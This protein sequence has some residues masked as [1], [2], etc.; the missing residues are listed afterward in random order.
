MTSHVTGADL[1]Q[2]AIWH[3][4]R[5][6][7][8]GSA[9]GVPAWSVAPTAA[10]I[11]PII[12]AAGGGSGSFAVPLAVEGYLV[13]V[14]DP[15]PDA[16]AALRR[17]ADERG[18]ADRVTAEQG[19]LGDLTGIVGTETADL[20]LC[21]SVLDVVDDPGAALAG[22]LRVLRPGGVLSL[23]VAG[24]AATVLARALAG[25]F[26][27]A[28]AVLTGQGTGAPRAAAGFTTAEIVALVDGAGAD[29]VDVHGVR[30]FA[31]L[32]PG[33]LVDS[34]AFTAQRLLRLEL[35]AAAREPFRDLAAQLHVLA[36][37]RAAGT[38]CET[39]TAGSRDRGFP[40]MKDPSSG[41]DQV[42]GIAR[43]QPA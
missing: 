14:V 26:E 12:V 38:A 8:P 42:T 17:R 9:A 36:R 28:Q 37:R 1:R 18:V 20:L 5:T 21:H 23:V 16:L 4:L 2:A 39:G 24:R 27:Q 3:G 11:P 29:V 7:L 40:G 31:D 34:D 10:T 43:F 22:A 33:A 41:T 13:I 30:V 6:V 35:A 15:S 19:D 25:R 32:V